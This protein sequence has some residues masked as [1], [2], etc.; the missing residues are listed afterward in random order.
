M[1]FALSTVP[2]PMVIAFLGTLSIP[3]KAGAASTRVIWSKVMFLVPELRWD[4]GS[5]K[6]I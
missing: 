4:P 2:I 3:K 6:P 5:L 1:R